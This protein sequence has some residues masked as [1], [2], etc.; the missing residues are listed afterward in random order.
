MNRGLLIWKSD[1]RIA[2]QLLPS[3][4]ESKGT[5][6]PAMFCAAI[7]SVN[8]GVSSS[9]LP[10]N[11][12][13]RT[14]SIS[15]LLLLYS[16]SFSQ[17]RA[18]E[19][20]FKFLGPD[21]KFDRCGVVNQSFWFQISSYLYFVR[22]SGCFYTNWGVVSLGAR[23]RQSV[24]SLSSLACSIVML[25]ISFMYSPMLAASMTISLSMQIS[26]SLHFFVYLSMAS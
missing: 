19:N 8:T 21:L 5:A 7:A 17:V 24:T 9:I 4:R 10:L 18:L 20:D 3:G 1:S 22:V 25:S 13:A 26:M 11:F 16:V 23:S 14:E 2:K 15:L 12:A 6:S